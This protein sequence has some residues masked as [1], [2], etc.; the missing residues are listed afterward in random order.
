MKTITNIIWLLFAGWELAIGYAVAGVLNCLSIVGIPFGIQSFKLAAYCLWP[1]GRVVVRN[2]RG[3]GLLGCLGNVVWVVLGGWYM[4]LLHVL[5]GI[6]LCLTIIGIPMG[7]ANF[8]MVGLSLAP[9]GKSI[10]AAE[11]ARRLGHNV[12]HR[13]G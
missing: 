1:F 10:L 7:I 2:E 8:K 6:L 4:A 11:D 12:Q 5:T 9:F 3:A 13:V